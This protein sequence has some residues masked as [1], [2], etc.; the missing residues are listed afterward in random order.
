M[1]E[2]TGRLVIRLT[3]QNCMTKFIKSNQRLVMIMSKTNGTIDKFFDNYLCAPRL[4][5]TAGYSLRQKI[6]DFKAPK[7]LDY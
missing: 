3:T 2:L 1:P 5:P 4:F 6:I 7:K